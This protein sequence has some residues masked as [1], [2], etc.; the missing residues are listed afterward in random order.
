MTNALGPCRSHTDARR[1]D[2]ESSRGS[3]READ[4]EESPQVHR[5]EAEEVDGK[6][7]I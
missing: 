7:Y 6:L 2:H 4:V 1:V 5:E 3:G